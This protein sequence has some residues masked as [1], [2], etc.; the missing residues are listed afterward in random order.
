MITI[1]LVLLGTSH[2]IRDLQQASE[3]CQERVDSV[4]AGAR[5]PTEELL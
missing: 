2:S 1:P 4:R 5:V 3:F